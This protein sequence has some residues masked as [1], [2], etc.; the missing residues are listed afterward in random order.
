[1]PNRYKNIDIRVSD[2]GKRYKSNM[3]YPDIPLSENDTY[4][5]T[6][7]SDRYDSLAQQFYGDS[8]LWW[9]IASANNY[10]KDGLI[11]TP[12]VQLRI[13]AN[14]QDI[15]ADFYEFNEKR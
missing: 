6:T 8:S 7:G 1:M 4:I 9:I 12:G 5:I 13:P 14:G 15:R 2:S 11:P 3:I 10:K